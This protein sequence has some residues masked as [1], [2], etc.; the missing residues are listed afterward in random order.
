MNNFDRRQVVVLDLPASGRLLILRPENIVL[1]FQNKLTMDVGALCYLERESTKITMQRKANQGRRVRLE[2]LCPRRVNHI[3][4]FIDFISNQVQEGNKKSTTLHNL[5]QHFS[6]FLSWADENGHSSALDNASLTR[7]SVVAYALHIRE[8]VAAHEISLDFGAVIQH[9]TFSIVGELLE[10]ENLTRGINLLQ[11][12]ANLNPT[13][14]PDEASQGRTLS[15]AQALFYGLSDL[16][17]EEKPY[18]CQIPMPPY[19]NYPDNHMWIFPAGVWCQPP[20]KVESGRFRG[21]FNYA[22]GCLLTS[23]KAPASELSLGKRDRFAEMFKAAEYLLHKSNQ[24]MRHWHRR[25]M[26]MMA[27][28]SFVQMFMARTGMNWEQAV[29]LKWENDDLEKV[30]AIRQRFR[31]IKHRAG[32]KEV[33]FQLPLEF[34]PMFKLFLKLRK[35]LLKEHPAFEFLF[36]AMG[37]RASGPPTSLRTSLHV[38]GGFLQRIDTS[39]TPPRSREWRAAKADWLLTRTDLSTTSQIMQNTERTTRVYYAA[40]SLEAHRSEMSAFLNR[41]VLE[42]RE[43]LIEFEDAALGSCASYG[44][45]KA[46]SGNA[47][48]MIPNCESPEAGCLFCDKF[49]VH[50]DDVDV[51]KLLS[52]RYCLTRVS[53]LSGFAEKSK[54]IIHRIEIILEEITRLNHGI[55]L[56]IENEVEEGELDPY[57]GNKFD[58]L[59]RL[60]LINESE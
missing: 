25:Y 5:S 26:G 2:S 23:L 3:R 31:S 30:S 11:K 57:W 8:R 34:M 43:A 14:P 33:Y 41:M 17:L 39:L 46:I 52:C 6:R 12:G 35:Y 50:A 54:S 20:K 9:R 22:D 56:R 60:G 58:M 45:P 40:S 4:K 42:K 53:Y 55:V 49:K 51:R 28:N 47:P 16:V 21:V 44:D 13:I 27:L 59:L 19:L 38:T 36:F 32:G 10:I 15:L 18:P 37:S 24:D 7:L 29:N 1:R 48:A